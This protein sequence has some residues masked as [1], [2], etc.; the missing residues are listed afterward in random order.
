MTS[1]RAIQDM[2]KATEAAALADIQDD[3]ELEQKLK[4][5]Q[6]KAEARRRD[7]YAGEEVK[8]PGALGDGAARPGGG[9]DDESPL[10]EERWNPHWQSNLKLLEVSGL[11]C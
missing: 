11:E 6:V 5:L 3:A 2:D 7:R 8:E 9:A 10:P 1:T 4:A